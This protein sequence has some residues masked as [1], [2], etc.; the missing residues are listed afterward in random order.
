[1]TVNLSPTTTERILDF[2]GGDVQA[3]EDFVAGTVALIDDLGVV[4]ATEIFLVQAGH[5]ACQLRVVLEMKGVVIDD[6]FSYRK[7]SC[8][9]C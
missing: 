7:V 9:V 1:M 6:E 4:K 3:A 8:D 5:A 2:C